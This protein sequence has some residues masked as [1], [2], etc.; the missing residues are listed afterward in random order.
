MPKPLTKSN[1]ETFKYVLNQNFSITLN[2]F[3][4]FGI[5]LTKF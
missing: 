1:D 2:F 5:I 4:N 3:D